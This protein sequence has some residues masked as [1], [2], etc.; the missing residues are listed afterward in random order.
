MHLFFDFYKI[1]ASK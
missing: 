1:E